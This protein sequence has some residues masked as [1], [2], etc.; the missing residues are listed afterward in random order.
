[1][2][3]NVHHSAVLAKEKKRAPSE[4]SFSSPKRDDNKADW[5]K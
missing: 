2:A 1:M 4:W 3:K 5:W